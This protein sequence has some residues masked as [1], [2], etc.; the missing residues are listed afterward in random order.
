MRWCSDPVNYVVGEVSGSTSGY[1]EASRCRLYRFQPV[2]Y[3]QPTG[4]H[5]PQEDLRIA[6][7][8]WAAQTHEHSLVATQNL[9]P[10]VVG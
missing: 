3:I 10:Q 4:C 5:Q 1:Q 8:H 9:L 7:R 6:G 2:D